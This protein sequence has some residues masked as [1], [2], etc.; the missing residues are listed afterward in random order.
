MGA[1]TAH[2]TVVDAIARDIAAGR[3]Q[4]GDCLPVE[5]ELCAA[6]SVRRTTVREALKTL[7]AKGIVSVPPKT[8]TRILPRECWRLLDPDVFA[9]R[10]S[11]EVDDELVHDLID[12]RLVI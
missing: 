4:P 3:Y 1:Q 7:S 8:G 10:M 2:R 11:G 5:Q 12:I 6:F 9:W